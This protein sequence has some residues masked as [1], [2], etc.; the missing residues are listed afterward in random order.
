MSNIRLYES[1][2]KRIALQSGLMMHMK[3]FGH[4]S[5]FLQKYILGT[6]ALGGVWGTVDPL[7][8][9]HTIINALEAGVVALDT[10]PAYGDAELLVGKVLQQWQGSRPQVSTKVGRLKSYA[11]DQGIYDYTPAGMARSVECSLETLGVPVIDI[12]FLHEPA[13]IPEP[14]IE[15][16]V[17][18]MLQ[19]KQNGIAAKIGL[20]GNYP[21]SFLKYLNAGVFDVVMEY[22]RLNACCVDALDTSLPECCNKGISYW[23]ASPLHMGLLGRNFQPFLQSRPDWLDQRFVIAASAVNKIAGE[24]QLSLSSVALRFLQN[25]PFPINLVLGPAN[26]TELRQSLD[27]ISRGPLEEQLYNKIIHAIKNY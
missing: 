17:E 5:D 4:S 7:I 22:N 1:C 9:E 13:A 24:Q 3:E 23:A 11:S 8:S 26:Q 10:A 2:L 18:T 15:A 21:A 20:G 19:F 27:A 12:L 16:A 6:A 14:G 25:I